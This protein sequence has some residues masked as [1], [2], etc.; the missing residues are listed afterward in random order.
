MHKTC[1]NRFTLHACYQTFISGG[2]AFGGGVTGDAVGKP[3]TAVRVCVST[4]LNVKLL[5]IFD[6]GPWILTFVSLTPVIF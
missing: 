6:E 4:F 1:P 5:D 3:V 2:E